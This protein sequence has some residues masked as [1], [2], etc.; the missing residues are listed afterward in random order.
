M[1]KVIKIL[2]LIFD[3]VDKV[4]RY[5]AMFIFVACLVTGTVFLFMAMAGGVDDELV[6]AIIVYASSITS[7]PLYAFGE[8]IT[9]LK[10]INAKMK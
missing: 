10:Q 6:V 8:I 3:N 1:E 4:I 7:F 9:Q 5:S 2:N